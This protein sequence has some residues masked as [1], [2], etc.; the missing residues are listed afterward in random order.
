[1][2]ESLVNDS[3][4]LQSKFID[5]KKFF[6]NYQMI[7]NIIHVQN[8]IKDYSIFVVP[9]EEAYQ[10]L[11]EKAD[12]V[13]NDFVIKVNANHVQ[14]QSW[15]EMIKVVENDPQLHEYYAEFKKKYLD[16]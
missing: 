14:V 12:Q 13:I 6:K 3:P 10:K 1:M 9:K 4:I 7:R 8:P 5:Q 15:E 11:Y 16:F 2:Y